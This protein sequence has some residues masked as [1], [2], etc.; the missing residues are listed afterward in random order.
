VIDTTVGDAFMP[1]DAMTPWEIELA[2]L[3]ERIVGIEG[4]IASL[5]KEFATLGASHRGDQAAVKMA[6]AIQQRTN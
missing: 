5:D 6:T 2:E 4:A 3:R 1:S